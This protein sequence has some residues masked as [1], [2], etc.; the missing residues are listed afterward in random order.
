[1]IPLPT[2]PHGQSEERSDPVARTRTLTSPL[3]INPRASLL[4]SPLGE[5]APSELNRLMSD[6]ESSLS[7]ESQAPTARRA[8]VQPVMGGSSD[9]WEWPVKDPV[10]SSVHPSLFFTSNPSLNLP[11]S[12]ASSLLTPSCLLTA[13]V[14]ASAA[15]EPFTPLS[16]SST[17][18]QQSLPQ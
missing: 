4:L 3:T 14:A 2:H 1:M 17:C 15:S 9:P 6:D 5:V 7:S 18:P 11:E 13:A 10:C 16:P 12:P 8:E